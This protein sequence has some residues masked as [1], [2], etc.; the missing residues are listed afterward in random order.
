MPY[1]AE[2]YRKGANAIYLACP[3]DVAREVAAMLRQAAEDREALEQTRD[4]LKRCLDKNTEVAERAAQQTAEHQRHAEAWVGDVAHWQR[5]ASEQKEALERAQ[6]E[7]A[8][9]TARWEALKNYISEPG[10]LSDKKLEAVFVLL[11]RLERE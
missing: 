10:L 11:A 8:R 7:I 5:I 2:D 4:H 1:T 6:A 3:E 9:L